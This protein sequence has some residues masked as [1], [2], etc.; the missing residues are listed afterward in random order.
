[1]SQ[2]RI[3]RLQDFAA[4]SKNTKPCSAPLRMRQARLPLPSLLATK[5]D[6]LAALSPKLAAVI[7]RLVDDML[8]EVEGRRP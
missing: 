4:R 3:V 2:H 1:M 5:S 6:R 7:E 8:D